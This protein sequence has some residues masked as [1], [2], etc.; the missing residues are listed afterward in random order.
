MEVTMTPYH[1]I[2][3]GLDTIYLLNG[4]HTIEEDGDTFTSINDIEQLH[5]QIAKALINKHSPLQAKEFKFLRVE[6]NLSQKA[7]AELLGVDS[8]TVARWEKG[9]TAIPRG[10]D[11][12]LRAYYLESQ[13]EDSK[14]GLMLKTLAE[15]ETTEV[16]TRIEF[17]EQ[18]HRWIR[19]VA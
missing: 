14:I 8:Q 7:L 11:V 17:E 5:L 13:A 6:L 18:D 1:Y 4:V 3:S 19:A 16:M 15:A 12:L 10:S 9:E 2:E